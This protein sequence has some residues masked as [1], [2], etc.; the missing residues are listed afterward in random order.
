MRKLLGESRFV[1][2]SNAHGRERWYELGVTPSLQKF[3][4]AV[5]SF[6]KALASPRGKSEG[7]QVPLTIV[8]GIAA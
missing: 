1:F 8:T 7:R 3:F 6:G 2:Y 4:E 5:P